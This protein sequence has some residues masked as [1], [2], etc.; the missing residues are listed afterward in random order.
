MEEEGIWSS[1]SE[2][3]ELQSYGYG[4]SDSQID[5]YSTAGGV[6]WLDGGYTVFGQVFD[7]LDVV[8]DI[9]KVDTDDNDKPTKDVIIETMTVEEYSGEP[10]RFYITDY[11]GTAASETD[12]DAEESS[13]T[14][15]EEETSSDEE[16]TTEETSTDPE[17]ETTT[18]E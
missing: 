11:D 12:T 10:V 3:D 2:I 7:G 8:F 14:Q 17:Q 9:S 18:A 1:D 13:D 4:L 5:I 15:N 6:P 16:T